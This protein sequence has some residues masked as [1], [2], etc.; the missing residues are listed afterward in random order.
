VPLLN[1]C[2]EPPHPPP[3]LLLATAGIFFVDL[4]GDKPSRLAEFS[5]FLFPLLPPILLSDLPATAVYF[6]PP[7]LFY[8]LAL[9]FLRCRVQI[10]LS[11]GFRLSFATV[12]L[13]D[14]LNLVAHAFWTVGSRPSFS[15]FFPPCFFD[16]LLTTIPSIS[17]GRHCSFQHPQSTIQ[18]MPCLPLT[19]HAS[20]LHFVFRLDL[21]EVIPPS[22][23]RPYVLPF[24][25]AP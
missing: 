25:Y 24:G 7:T 22:S 20:R 17:Y 1:Y 23:V 14:C 21:T 6:S 8:V 11:F 4:I 13:A 16:S 18:I 5:F 10:A 15:G 12:V 2:D 9:R 19:L 3:I